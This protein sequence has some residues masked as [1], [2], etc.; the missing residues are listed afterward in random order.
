MYNKKI[1]K[2]ESKNYIFEIDLFNLYHG[3]TLK[4]YGFEILC[5]RYLEKQSSVFGI[6][7]N[8]DYVYIDLFWF[9]FKVFD[10][11]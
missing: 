2:M 3:K 7:G 6:I 4:K 9:R 11:I 1:I 5:F 8:S 10:K